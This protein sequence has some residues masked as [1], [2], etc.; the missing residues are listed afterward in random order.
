MNRS[1]YIEKYFT[2]LNTNQF[3]KLKIQRKLQNGKYKELYGI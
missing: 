3:N 2:L 1:A